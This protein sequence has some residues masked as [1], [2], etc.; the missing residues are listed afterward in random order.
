MG[1]KAKHRGEV[2]GTSIQAA[3]GESAKV[4]PKAATSSAANR[5]NKAIKKRNSAWRIQAVAKKALRK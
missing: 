3:G 4:K 1:A 5:P 2:K